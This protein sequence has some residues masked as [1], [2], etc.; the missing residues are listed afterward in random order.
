MEG[1]DNSAYR[2]RVEKSELFVRVYMWRVDVLFETAH[3]GSLM[4]AH[5]QFQILSSIWKGIMRRINSKN[6][7]RKSKKPHI[8]VC[9]WVKRG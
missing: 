8:R 5:T 4:N 3:L 7:N 1:S 6:K 9:K 2:L